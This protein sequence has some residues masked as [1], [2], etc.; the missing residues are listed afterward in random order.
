M[1]STNGI[2]ITATFDP[3]TETWTNRTPMRYARWYPTVTTLGDGR[4]LAVSGRNESGSISTISEVYD[5]Q[6]DTWTEL[7][8]AS[9][10]QALYLF[11]YLFANGQVF[12]AAPRPPRSTS[13]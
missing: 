3:L 4:V 12:D 11:M 13:T 5:P 6:T 9:R 2:K 7:T 10:S 8:G 1:S